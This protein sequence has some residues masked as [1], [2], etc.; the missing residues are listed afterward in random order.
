MAIPRSKAKSLVEQQHRLQ[1]VFPDC[2]ITWKRG[3]LTFET[4][5]T[6]TPTSDTYRIRLTY[7]LGQSP[8]V[9][10]VSP[11]LG[12]IDDRRL[13]H[14]YGGGALCLYY[15]G[16]WRREFSLADTILPWASE[17]LANYETWA[18]TGRWCGGGTH[19][20]RWDRK[21]RD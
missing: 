6:P 14:T 7:R 18:F 11:E 3:L 19:P 21:R 17:W 4:E 10:V 9:V 5:L 1:E 15:R 20:T 2:Q 16:E 13:P 12:R 8:K